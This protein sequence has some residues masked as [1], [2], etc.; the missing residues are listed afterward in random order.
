MRGYLPL[1]PNVA[2]TAQ[3]VAANQALKL[4][5]LALRKQELLFELQG[6]QVNR[7]AGET[8]MQDLFPVNQRLSLTTATFGSILLIRECIYVAA[9]QVPVSPMTGP[10]LVILGLAL[11]AAE[12]YQQR[13]AHQRMHTC[14]SS[15]RICA[16]QDTANCSVCHDCTSDDLALKKALDAL[17]SSARQ[18]VIMWQQC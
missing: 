14:C 15:S 8:S 2:P 13:S 6:Y 9:L 1:D 11:T 16:P 12:V 17:R 18:A 10:T 7:V 3:L 4:Q 5:E